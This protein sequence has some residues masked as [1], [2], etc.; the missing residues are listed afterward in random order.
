VD[1]PFFSNITTMI[2]TENHDLI[3][4]EIALAAAT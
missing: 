1:F 3:K 2:V 4:Y